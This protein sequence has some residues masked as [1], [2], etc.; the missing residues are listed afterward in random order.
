MNNKR[1][2]VTVVESGLNTGEAKTPPTVTAYENNSVGPMDITSIDFF[3]GNPRRIRSTEK[4]I[5]LKESV[6][7]RGVLYPIQVA[8]RPSSNRFVVARGGNTR[9]GVLKELY[10]ETGDVKYKYIP[11]Q[12]VTYKDEDELFIFHLIEN[13]K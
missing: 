2:L 11:A 1:S 12:E 4:W 6:R 9:L 5:E 3:E 8:R 10:E 13:C 7:A